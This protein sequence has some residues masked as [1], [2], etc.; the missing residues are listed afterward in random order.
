L[1][2]NGLPYRQELTPVTFLERA[3]LVHARRLAV[4][5]ED[6]RITYSEFRDRSRRFASALRAN[7][8]KK[9]ERVAFLA[10]NSEPLLLAHF[11]V[12]LAG[13]VLVALNTRLTPDE[14]AYIVDHSEAS[15]V[16]VDP[17]LAP[18]LAGVRAPRGRTPFSPLLPAQTRA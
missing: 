14:V 9:G 2:F 16:L 6:R 13:G 5:D 11:A 18:A 7:G 1:S 12:P 17:E 8:L 3:G 15:L 4:V 10:L